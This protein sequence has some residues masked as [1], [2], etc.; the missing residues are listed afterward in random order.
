MMSPAARLARA[1]RDLA[2]AEQRL[3]DVE[4]WQ[5]GSLTSESDLRQ[6][7]SAAADRVRRLRIRVQIREDAA[8]R[9]ATKEGSGGA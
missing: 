9:T 3:A 4:R 2:R 8:K 6:M 1:Q 7:R 5:P